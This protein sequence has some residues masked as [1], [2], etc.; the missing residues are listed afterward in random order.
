MPLTSSAGA[1]SAAEAA[2]SPGNDLHLRPVAAQHDQQRQDRPLYPCR[3]T[4]AAQMALT[5]GVATTENIQRQEAIVI[6]IAPWKKLPSGRRAAG[7]VRGVEVGIK[8]AGR[9]VVDLTNCSNGTSWMATAVWRPCSAP[10]GTFGVE[11][12]PGCS[13]RGEV[14]VCS[15]RSLRSSWWSFPDLRSP[16]PAHRPLPQQLQQW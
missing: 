14:A 3:I 12:W 1:S 4:V 16:A 8:S 7:C 11:G 15:A 13:T 9:L 5:N 10:D 6:V 2:S